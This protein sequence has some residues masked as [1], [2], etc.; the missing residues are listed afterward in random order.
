VRCEF[1]LRSSALLTATIDQRWGSPRGSRSIQVKQSIGQVLY[2]AVFTANPLKWQGFI[3][4]RDEPKRPS[5]G[6]LVK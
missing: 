3:P 5:H 6:V 1:L 2:A 4:F